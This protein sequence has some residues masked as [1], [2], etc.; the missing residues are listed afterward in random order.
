MFEPLST[1]TNFFCI[2]LTSWARGHMA[3]LACSTHTTG[4]VAMR[5]TF[6]AALTASA[7]IRIERTVP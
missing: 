1:A 2:D 7:R 6:V 5:V 4:G 3:G